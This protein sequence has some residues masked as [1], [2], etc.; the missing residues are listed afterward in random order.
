MRDYQAKK[1]NPY[2]L[3]HDVYMQ[4]KNRLMGYNRLRREKM[5]II[6]GSPLPQDGMPRSTDLSNP[7]QRKVIKLEYIEATIRAIDEAAEYMY[8][9]LKGKVYDEFEPIRAY[10][11]YDY[12]NYEFVRKEENDE[13]PS[14]RTWNRFKSMFS[15]Y[16]AK[17]LNIF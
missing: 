11:S 17:N 1:N 3:P 8:S 5:D 9:K 14:R 12:F 16:I 15:Y 2:Y 6:H 7:T 10:W 13:G 4:V